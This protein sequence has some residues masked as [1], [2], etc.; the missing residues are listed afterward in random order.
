MNQLE[1]IYNIYNKLSSFAITIVPINDR[2]MALRIQLRSGKYL[3]LV[4]VY[5]PTMQ[6]P[7]EEKEPFYQSL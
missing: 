3:K 5:A 7:Q 1:S 4:S 2:L 6:R